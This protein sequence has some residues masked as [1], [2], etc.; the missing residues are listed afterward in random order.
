MQAE[1]TG[2]PSCKAHTHSLNHFLTKSIKNS[3]PRL[4]ALDLD[5]TTV[6]RAKRLH[7]Q[8]RRA[9]QW[10]RAQ[11]VIV[12]IVTGRLY[13]STRAIAHRLG[14]EGPVGCM[15]GAELVDTRDDRPVHTRTLPRSVLA[16]IRAAFRRQ[17]LAPFVFAA[18]GMH[19]DAGGA[20]WIRPMRTW[21]GRFVEHECVYNAPF[22]SG[23]HPVFTVGAQGR[24]TAVAMARAT[25][26]EQHPHLDLLTFASGRGDFWWLE[27]RDAGDDK[28]TALRAI[29]AH[30]NIPMRETLALGD[31]HNDAPLLAAA[32]RA[33]CMGHAPAAIR[34]LC[35]GVLDADQ[36]TGGGIAELAHRVYGAPHP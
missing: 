6:D 9:V 22:W 20:P 21:A 1:Y 7:P 28:G 36:D 23:T 3:V 2:R 33:Y 8:D 30:H 14:I 17:G 31:W 16:A 32:G 35:E 34:A 26:A 29:A 10:L 13:S 4:L 24:A 19:Y 11:G 25:L 12:T 15:N 5:G 18:D 27:A